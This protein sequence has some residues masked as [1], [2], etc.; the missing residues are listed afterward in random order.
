MH[1]LNIWPIPIPTD[2]HITITPQQI[3]YCVSKVTLHVSA[4]TWHLALLLKSYMQRTKL[5][6]TYVYNRNRILTG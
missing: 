5:V 1:G 2:T 3:R 4:K 6:A